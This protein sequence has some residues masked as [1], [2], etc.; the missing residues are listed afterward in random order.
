MTF[1]NLNLALEKELR[2]EQYQQ[3]ESVRQQ[4]AAAT[5]PSAHCHVCGAALEP[6]AM[7]CEE[8][9]AP[10]GAGSCGHCGAAIQPGMGICPV[11]GH[12]ATTNC[13][14][15][16]SAMDAGQMFCGECGNSRGGITCPDCG[17]LNFRN[18]CRKCNRPLNAMALQAVEEAL[19]DPKFIHAKKL[20]DEI[21]DIEEEIAR[22]EA[23][24]ARP[25]E[26]VLEVDDTM[27]ASTRRLLEE[28][29]SLSGQPGTPKAAPKAKAAEPETRKAAPTMSVSEPSAKRPASAPASGGGA[30]GSDF[31]PADRLEQLRQQHRA[32]AA[33]LQASLAAM[34]PDPAAPP[35]VKRDYVCAR[36]VTTVSTT[37]R[38]R[39]IRTGWV[40][41]RCNV[42][43]KVPSECAFEEYGGVWQTDTITETISTTSTRQVN[44]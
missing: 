42:W 17:T 14:F 39:Q 18:F 6:G 44:L 29:A 2:R 15:C 34:V 32:K 33:E 16:G 40:C 13:T 27:S 35:Q 21:L 24:L 22:L 11:C 31:G 36:M 8:C 5:Q 37:K 12:P 7:F 4:T 38:T 41:N 23:E 28:F 20:A 30:G 43:H 3:Q 26:R 1:F 19:R 9:G 10:Q 25:P